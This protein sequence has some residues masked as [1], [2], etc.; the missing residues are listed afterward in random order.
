MSRDR[1]RDVA[2][3]EDAGGQLLEQRLEEMMVRAVDDRHLD[4]GRCRAL[5]ANSPP[6]PAPT[7]ATR[8]GCARVC[9]DLPFGSM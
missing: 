8:C 6:K 9:S 7:I 1:Q 3:G 5:A 2:L 4:V